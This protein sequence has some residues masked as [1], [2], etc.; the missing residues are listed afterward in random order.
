M[1]RGFSVV[2][3]IVA[4]AVV[5]ALAA[6]VI[7]FYQAYSER[8]LAGQIATNLRVVANGI[9]EFRN[10]VGVLPLNVNQL[11]VKPATTESD[12]CGVSL[13]STQKLAFWNGPYVSRDL[14]ASQLV[15]ETDTLGATFTRSST[16]PA[17]RSTEGSVL[18]RVFNTSSDRALKVDAILDG[19]LTLT[20]GPLT[21]AMSG[22][23]PVLTYQMGVA[24]C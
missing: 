4:L 15:M 7:P 18:I 8:A 22:S 13:S 21:W 3:L 2:E 5:A 6:M 16:S 10:S 1:M 9:K 24:G 20:S 19:D 17:T 14:I 23:Q 11:I 12:L